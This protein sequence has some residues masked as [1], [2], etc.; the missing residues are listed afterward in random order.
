MIVQL[1]VMHVEFMYLRVWL[2]LQSYNTTSQLTFGYDVCMLVF[3]V[4]TYMLNH[5]YPDFEI[6]L[7]MFVCE[8]IVSK[9]HLSRL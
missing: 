7:S 9:T 2:E 5:A 1:R 4:H 8:L 3:D 6:H